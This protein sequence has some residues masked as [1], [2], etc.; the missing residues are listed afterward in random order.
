MATPVLP[1]RLYKLR[2]LAAAG[3]SS[4]VTLQRRITEGRIPAVKVS[5][6]YK[7][8]ESDLPLIAQPVGSDSLDLYVDAVLGRFD[9]LTP[10]QME[11]PAAKFA[12]AP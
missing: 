6:T 4:R 10:E 9:D 5:N 7:I 2:D 8:R 12:P 3:Y 1:E 11:R